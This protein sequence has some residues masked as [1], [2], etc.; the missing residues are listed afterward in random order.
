MSE[1]MFPMYN[2]LEHTGPHHKTIKN[3]IHNEH[4]DFPEFSSEHRRLMD[5]FGTLLFL[6]RGNLQSAQ[7]AL[8]YFTCDLQV[9]L[10]WLGQMHDC[11]KTGAC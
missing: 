8:R 10:A 5:T 1:L 2:M 3:N 9:L 7:N 6:G 11:E 4:H